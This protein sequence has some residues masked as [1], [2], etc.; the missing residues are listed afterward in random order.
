MEKFFASF[1]CL[2]FATQMIPF[3]YGSVCVCLP[4][5]FTKHKRGLGKCKR[6]REWK[7]HAIVRQISSGERDK[8]SFREGL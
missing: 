3:S 7:R 2:S 4:Q 5:L 6:G 8:D 1:E